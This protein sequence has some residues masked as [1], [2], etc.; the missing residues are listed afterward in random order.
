MALVYRLVY[1]YS[2]L[3]ISNISIMLHCIALYAIYLST[4]KSNQNIIL[5]SLSMGEIVASIH[6]VLFEVGKQKKFF[7]T[8]HAAEITLHCVHVASIYIL[9]FI[10]YVLILDRLVMVISPLKYN[11]R[12]SR[13]KVTAMA[14]TCWFAGT[15]LGVLTN[16]LPLNIKNIIDAVGWFIGI[17]Q[18]LLVCITYV[19]IILKVR[20]SRNLYGDRN[21]EGQLKFRK[22]FLIPTIVISTNILFFTC[23]LAVQAFF[24][25]KMLDKNPTG[26]YIVSALVQFLP[27]VGVVTD[28]LTY[29]LLSPHY[30]RNLTRVMNKF[31]KNI[32][33]IVTSIGN[34]KKSR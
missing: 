5:T 22:E 16:L 26:K 23:P 28:A 30:R 1:Y 15:L 33:E 32:V 19:I 24:P 20:G 18:L 3:A 9:V 2:V 31:Y 17:N 12:M 6:R 8:R 10:C 11:L 7:I 13:T 27:H 14:I 25:W 21:N 34:R 4:K 29:V